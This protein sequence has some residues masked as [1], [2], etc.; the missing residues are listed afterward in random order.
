MLEKE[1]DFWRCAQNFPLLKEEVYP[2]HAMAHGFDEFRK[3]GNPPEVLEFGCGGGSDTISLLRRGYSVTFSDIVPGNVAMT[4]ER[5]SKGDYSR[6]TPVLLDSTVPL[7]FKDKQFDAI[8]SHGV[9]HHIENENDRKELMFEFRRVLRK[10]GICAI[11]LYTEALYDKCAKLLDKT[12]TCYEFGTF[13]DGFGCYAQ[14]YNEEMGYA[15]IEPAGFKVIRAIGY[16]NG[17][18]RTF[19]AKAV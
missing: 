6:Y 18:F 19:F 13:T 7:P 5:A 1:K 14:F 2:A 12:P 8:T 16:N 4:T 17:D 9:V 10:D 3:L 11:M 15:L